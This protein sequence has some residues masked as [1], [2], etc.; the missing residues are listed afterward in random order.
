MLSLNVKMKCPVLSLVHM[1]SSNDLCQVKFKCYWYLLL[2]RQACKTGHSWIEFFLW[3]T[4]T[5]IYILFLKHDSFS[6]VQDESYEKIPSQFSL[7]VFCDLLTEDWG[8]LKA[9]RHLSN[10]SHQQMYTLVYR[11][12]W[13]YCCF[14]NS[15]P[16]PLRGFWRENINTDSCYQ[17][18][19]TNWP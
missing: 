6:W 1:L 2:Q 9:Q 19:Q 16:I 11:T 14:T 13:K 4:N 5:S 12:R 17:T 15:I 8:V 7:A 18:W 3:G 10:I